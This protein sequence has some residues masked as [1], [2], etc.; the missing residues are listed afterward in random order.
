MP[1]TKPPGV[2]IKTNYEIRP[3]SRVEILFDKNIVRSPL[4]IA[5]LLII[6]LIQYVSMTFGHSTIRHN[7]L[8]RAFGD[9]SDRFT[10]ERLFAARQVSI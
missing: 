5:L 1:L 3:R 10:R 9:N 4:K 7:I 8:T 2:G 6:V